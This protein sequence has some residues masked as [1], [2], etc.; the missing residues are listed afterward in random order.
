MVVS[1][2]WKLRKSE[3]SSQSKSFGITCFN[4]W[5]LH[6]WWQ[7]SLTLPPLTSQLCE[8]HS[9]QSLLPSNFYMISPAYFSIVALTEIFAY[10]I[11]C[12]NSW[13]ISV[14]LG[15]FRTSHW[16]I[17]LFVSA[18]T[19]VAGLVFQQ[20]QQQSCLECEWSV[21]GIWIPHLVSCISQ[22]KQ[23]VGVCIWECFCVHLRML[24]KQVD[25]KLA[26]KCWW[27][28]ITKP[29]LDRNPTYV[30]IDDSS[31]H[32]GH[33]NTEMMTKVLTRNIERDYL[34]ANIFSSNCQNPR[35]H[36]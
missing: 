3:V 19:V 29:L 21:K 14:Y 10:F 11:P 1:K 36:L 24:G 4:L 9:C 35:V 26:G 22:S 32:A 25:A 33:L 17:F 2:F 12:H 30:T 15:L 27:L 7:H 31:W 6:L 8:L 20:Q 18:P 16:W 28:V 34:L 13:N 23:N 5:L